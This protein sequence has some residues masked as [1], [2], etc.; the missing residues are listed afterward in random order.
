MNL[1]VTPQI[2]VNQSIASARRHTARL[3]TLQEQASTGNRLLRPSDGP[4]E[5]ATVLADKAQDLRMDAYLENLRDARSTLDLS[6]SSLRETSEILSQAR[7]VAIEASHSTNDRTS[8]EAL[9][10]QVDALFNRL[11]NVANTQNAGRYL[12]G[13]TAVQNTPF[14]VTSKDSAGRALAVAYGGANERG[15][16]VVDSQEFVAT[17]YSGAQ[18]FQS[19][20]RG[21]TVFTGN[22]GAAPGSGTDSA[23]GQDTLLVQ[24]TA[25]TYEPGSGVQPG[26]GS[27]GSDTIL[28]PAGAHRLTIIDTSGIGAS[29][30]VSLDGGP[31]IS[32][33][34][35]DT[36]LKVTGPGGE[37]V[38]LNTTAISPGFNG[39]V[40]ITATGTLS[41]DGGA[42]QVGIDFS[43]NQ[44]VTDSQTGAVTN[45][46]SSQIRRTG[47]EH[48]DYTGTYDA[49]QILMALRDDLRNT[50]NLNETQ[51]IE[52]I[53]R[54][55]SELDRVRDS[56]L[57][58][59]GEQ[60]ASLEN[61][62]SLERRTQDL[63]LELR[64]QV[65]DLEAA[66]ISEVVLNLQSQ[67]NALRLT[68][69]AA[70]RVLDQ[71][72]LDFLR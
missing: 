18:V 58:I 17:N 32:F 6:V 57:E 59:V 70:A 39:D 28:G 61:L 43:T 47:T 65:S 11:L 50:S 35:A 9:A 41:V 55:L 31:P 69:A 68:L 64:K 60:S 15:E 52:S 63:Q 27:A 13:G 12:Y 40:A 66:D 21:T 3:G 5:T 37:T 10:Q 24:H 53:S 46:D 72:L 36:N 20:R 4:L 16:V 2:L 48:L 34:N 7:Q 42:S 19:R 54:R 56:V 30:T 51:Q 33:T 38:F 71:S 8:F 14:T 45:V 1:R 29:G 22:T 49:F 67:D 23:T 26:S 62:E 44:I 25:T